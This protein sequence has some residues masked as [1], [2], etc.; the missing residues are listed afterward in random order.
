MSGVDFRFHFECDA[1]D[2]AD[3]VALKSNRRSVIISIQHLPSSM[4]IYAN[5]FIHKQI[6]LNELNFQMQLFQLF[7]YVRWKFMQIIAI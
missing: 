6:E 4:Q 1:T 5:Y 3:A 7:N 2:A